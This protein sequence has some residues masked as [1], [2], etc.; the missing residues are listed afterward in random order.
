MG[1]R[2]PSAAEVVET[3]VSKTGESL[4]RLTDTA[5][6]PAFKKKWFLL[7]NK[8]R[9]EMLAISLSAVSAR[10]PLRVRV[11]LDEPNPPIIKIMYLQ[12]E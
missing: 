7:P 4:I 1:I 9:K 2:T 5:E 11:D 3:G 8:T 10:L 12:S 6:S